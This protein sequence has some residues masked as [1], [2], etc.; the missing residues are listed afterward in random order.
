MAAPRFASFRAGQ[1]AAKQTKVDGYTFDSKAEARRYG[2]LK[3]RQMQ[4]AISAL[5]V[6]PRY[7]LKVAG[8]K[9]TTYVADFEYR[10]D[11]GRLV[12]E[13]VKPEA[14]PIDRLSALKMKLFDALHA[15]FGLAVQIVR[16]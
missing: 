10:D 12:V 4:G 2:Y 3:L 5:R 13:D 1:R 6:H 16:M 14:A 7:D 15:E 9:L 11:D 8:R